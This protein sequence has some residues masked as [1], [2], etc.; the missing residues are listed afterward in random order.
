MKTEGKLLIAE[1]S[2]E[3]VITQFQLALWI[4]ILGFNQ[5]QIEYT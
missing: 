4:Y 1:N 5:L 2:G 3:V